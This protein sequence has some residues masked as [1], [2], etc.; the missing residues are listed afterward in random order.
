MLHEK[1]I[2]VARC[3]SVI[4]DLME[5]GAQCD[6]TLKALVKYNT[7]LRKDA[8]AL[9]Q[10]VKDRDAKIRKLRGWAFVGKAFVLVGIVV[11]TLVVAREVAP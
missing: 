3:R 11:T 10:D 9:D 4:S 6:T 8:I 5:A 1:A 2:N 7:R